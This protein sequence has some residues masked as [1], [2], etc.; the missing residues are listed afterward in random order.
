MNK[1]LLLLSLYCGN[2]SSIK[3]HHHNQ[4]DKTTEVYVCLMTLL[5]I[6][7]TA[8]TCFSISHHWSKSSKDTSPIETNDENVSY[9][10]IE[11]LGS[12]ERKI[13]NK[14]SPINKMKNLIKLSLNIHLKLVSRKSPYWPQ[15]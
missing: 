1:K 3:D 2:S 13:L 9:K 14:D 10:L 5:I 12:E 8:I 11:N 6:A 7:I 15:N 4:G